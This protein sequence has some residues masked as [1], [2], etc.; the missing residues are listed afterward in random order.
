M[1][2]QADRI[3]WLAPLGWSLEDLDYYTAQGNATYIFWQDR[4]ADRLQSWKKV[5]VQ[6]LVTLAYVALGAI[7]GRSCIRPW[8]IGG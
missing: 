3:E 5:A 2:R 4:F 1:D 7:L 6:P 8:L